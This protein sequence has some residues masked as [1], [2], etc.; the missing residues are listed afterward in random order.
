MAKTSS[1]YTAPLAA[2][3]LYAPQTIVSL[4]SNEVTGRPIAGDASY[5]NTVGIDRLWSG[6]EITWSTEDLAFSEIKIVRKKRDYAVG[7][8]DGLTVYEGDAFVGSFKDTTATGLDTYYYVLWFRNDI[9]EPW[10]TRY[11]CRLWEIALSPNTVPELLWSLLPTMYRQNEEERDNSEDMNLHV[12]RVIAPVIREIEDLT[13]FFPT[14]LDVDTTPGPNLKSI[15]QYIGLEPNLELSYT[16]Q[17]EEIKGAVES[18]K[19]KG[20][21]ATLE[22]MAQAIS[23]VPSSV[24]DWNQHLLISNWLGKTSLVADAVLGFNQLLPGDAGFRSLDI[25]G[26]QQ[27]DTATYGVYL[28]LPLTATLGERTVRKLYRSLGNFA[29]AYMEMDL[30]V[31]SE[32]QT[33]V[34]GDITESTW[35]EVDDS[36]AEDFT[37]QNFLVSNTLGSTGFTEGTVSLQEWPEDTSVEEVT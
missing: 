37:P 8:F 11:W 23:G 5:P 21:K 34:F 32:T 30:W 15:A 17:R 36:A 12:N 2:T 1:K 18:Y 3:P 24:I 13:G 27:F 35:M 6:I 26:G 20:L 33:D 16:Q 14:V 4:Y 28:N 31:V 19:R 25:T 7:V 22:Q 29:P 9:L 10:S